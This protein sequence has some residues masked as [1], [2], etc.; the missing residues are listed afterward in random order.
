MGL[1]CLK[2]YTVGNNLVLRPLTNN[3]EY[4]H[5]E[6]QLHDVISSIMFLGDMF[7][8]SRRMGQEEV[9]WRMERIQTAWLCLS[10]AKKHPW[11]ELATSLI[12]AVNPRN[13]PVTIVLYRLKFQSSRLIF[14]LE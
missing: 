12:I 2:L 1:E 13:I 6:T 9:S 4:M 11:L 3:D 5:H 8:V 7:C 10:L 14:L